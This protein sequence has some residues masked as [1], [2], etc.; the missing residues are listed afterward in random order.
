MAVGL[1]PRV[2]A[3]GFLPIT[4]A[5]WLQKRATALQRTPVHVPNRQR[6]KIPPLEEMEPAQRQAVWPNLNPK[7][8]G[9]GS[10][11]TLIW[12]TNQPA[13]TAHLYATP[14]ENQSP[15]VLDSRAPE[16]P[17]EASSMN[18]CGNTNPRGWPV[19]VVRSHPID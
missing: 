17:A 10:P 13:T 12:R 15:H 18:R 2:L 14:W 6:S 8:D 16:K 7:S 19:E 9:S 3:R 11:P 1:S 5:E 4:L